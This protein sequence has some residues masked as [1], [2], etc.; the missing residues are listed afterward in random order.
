MAVTKEYTTEAKVE[1]FLGISV[2]SG[3]LDDYINAI[4]AYIDKITGRN[5]IADEAASARLF[6]GSGN[7][8]LLIDDCVEIEKVEIGSNFYGDSFT[9]IEASG[10]NRYY[11]LPANNSADGVPITSLWARSMLFTV[12]LQNQRITAKWG[13]SEKVPED[14][15]WVATFLTASIYNMGQQGNVAGV[16]SERIGE[17]SVAFNNENELADF[18]KA[19][20]IL[21][22]YKKIIF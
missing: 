12:G 11:T 6:G 13:F 15:S 21:D 2:S 10:S 5:F 3:S 1:A 22:S 4:V 8:T 16:K 9:E 14:I 19:Q 18:Q 7:N 20:V 17:Y